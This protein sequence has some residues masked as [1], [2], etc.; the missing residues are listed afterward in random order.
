MGAC[1]LHNYTISSLLIFFCWFL[2]LRRPRVLRLWRVSRKWSHRWESDR[3]FHMI[4]VKFY[5]QIC[6]Q[7]VL[8]FRLKRKEVSNYKFNKTLN[9]LLV[10][11]KEELE[12]SNCLPHHCGCWNVKL[13]FM[14]YDRVNEN[15][16]ILQL[17]KLV[18]YTR[19]VERQWLVWVWLSNK[20]FVFLSNR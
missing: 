2:E 5:L 9:W 16:N 10:K 20:R 3:N 18:F 8:N 11:N 1:R 19:Y 17:L 6:A 14:G 12:W 13:L 15:F 4:V 7:E